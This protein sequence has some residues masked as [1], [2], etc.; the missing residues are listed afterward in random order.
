MCLTLLNGFYIE[1]LPS[2]AHDD[3]NQPQQILI[4][5]ILSVSVAVSVMMIVIVIILLVI[6]A[7]S[8]KAP[9]HYMSLTADGDSFAARQ[10]F[11]INSPQSSEEDLCLV[12]N[13]CHSLAGN[14]V[15]P[16]N[17]EYFTFDRQHGPGQSG[18]YQWA[19]NNFIECDMTLFVCNKSFYDAWNNGD[20]DQNSLVSASKL[21]LQGHLSQSE[22]VSQFGV[23]LLRQS[24]DR[25]IPSLYL[26]SL[27]KF[28]VFQNNQCKIE[29]LLEQ[30]CSS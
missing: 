16:I 6:H 22:S 21:L 19:E 18:I 12:R 4:V 29:A 7:R 13:L 2:N 8:H 1:I 14:S 3:N 9:D 27:Q 20:T 26:R 30:M 25:Y 24:D 17:Y 5:I 10:V 23:I 11:I 15:K 28:V